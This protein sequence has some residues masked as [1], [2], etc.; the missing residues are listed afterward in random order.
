MDPIAVAKIVGCFGIQGFVK[1]L[2]LTHH[3]ERLED[4]REVEIGDPNGE[5]TADSVEKVIRQHDRVLMKFKSVADRTAAEG[6]VG[7]YVFID[8]DDAVAPERGSFFVHDIV[9]CEVWST[10]GKYIGVVDNVYQQTAQDLW[11]VK[12]G[13][14][15]HLI[16]AVKEFIADVD[17]AKRRITVRLLEG[18]V[19]E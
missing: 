9:G 5:R 19:E 8:R 6:C 7:K 4:L 13:A 14:K 16:P 18:L 12:N 10:E 1:L 3:P 17:V 2:P 15:A 11:E